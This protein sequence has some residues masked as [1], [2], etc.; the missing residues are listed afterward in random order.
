MRSPRGKMSSA[1]G[2]WLRTNARSTFHSWDFYVAVGVGLGAGAATASRDVRAAAVPVT[3]TEAA[4]GVALTATVFGALAIFATF[5]DAGYRRVLE[6]AGGFRA[7]LMPYMVVGIVS[8]VSG[9][10]GLV[11]AL[12]LP[13]FGRWPSVGAVG[14]STLFCVWALTGTISLIELTIFHAAERAKLMTGADDAARA[15]SERRARKQV[16]R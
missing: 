14:V 3:I 7:A 15:L 4:I 13:A 6:L 12:V 11:A 2:S 1:L 9:M 16:A 10:V 5:Y 8:A